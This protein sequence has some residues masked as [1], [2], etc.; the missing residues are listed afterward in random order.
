MPD[1]KAPRNGTRIKVDKLQ[2]EEKEL[3]KE[4]QKKV[5][6]GFEGAEKALNKPSTG[7]NQPFETETVRF[8]VGKE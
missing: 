8:K 3:S 7:G 5:K 2:K 4:E 6:G 1:K